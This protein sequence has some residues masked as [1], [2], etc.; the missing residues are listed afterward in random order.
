MEGL[1]PTQRLIGICIYAYYNP[2][3]GYSWP[4]WKDQQKF[5]GVSENT[6]QRNLPTVLKHLNIRKEKVPG[7]NNR[8]YVS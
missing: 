3:K 5:C 2:E 1:N 6:I 8:Y 4:S 7:R